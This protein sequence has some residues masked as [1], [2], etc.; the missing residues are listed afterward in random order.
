MFTDNGFSL[1]S[2]F[3]KILRSP[4]KPLHLTLP[5]VVCEIEL[6]FFR[7]DS[8]DRPGKNKLHELRGVNY[9]FFF[10]YD[11]PVNLVIFPPNLDH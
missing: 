6:V 10:F 8:Q 5:W 11:F 4:E 9:Y 3:T 1:I 7:A 2:G